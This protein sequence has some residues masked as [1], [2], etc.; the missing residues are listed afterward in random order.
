MCLEG[1][2]SGECESLHG[3]GWKSSSVG[4][5]TTSQQNRIMA[6]YGSA[7]RVSFKVKPSGIVE[8]TGDDAR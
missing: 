8:L 1:L 5:M 6:R 3:S 2:L 4:E 7:I